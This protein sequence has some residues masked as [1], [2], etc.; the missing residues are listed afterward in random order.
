MNQVEN[1]N[2]S[3]SPLLASSAGSIQT[4]RKTEEDSQERFL[5]LLVTQM[6][7]Q[8]PLNPMDNA[9]IT[10][11]LA[12]ISTVSGIDKLN[13]TLEQLLA[14]SEAKRSLQAA[15]MIGRSVLIP[16]TSMELSNHAGIGGFELTEPVDRLVITIKDSSGI[17]VRN[18][19]LGPQAAGVSTFTWD[20][21]ANSGA[22]AVNGRYSFAVK[23]TRGDQAV[24]AS[25][26]AFGTVSSAVPGVDGIVLGVG[27]LGHA[28]M[29]DI[30]K[31]F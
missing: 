14:N 9:E 26:L 12:Q 23:A 20:G 27:E 29:D 18:I 30:K 1:V 11:Q 15:A 3:L 4:P 7:N 2:S 24:L 28:G 19:E 13:H 10:S 16:G 6:Q 21:V 31:I 22:E 25:T 8:D 5:K 17:A